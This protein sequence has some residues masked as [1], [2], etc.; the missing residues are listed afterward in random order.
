MSKDA[1][2][3]KYRPKKLSELVGQEHVIRILTNSIKRDKY[4]HAYIFAGKFGCGKTSTARIFAAAVNN[5][6]GP[7]PD[8][9]LSNDLIR[10]IFEGKHPDVKEI[11]AAASGSIDGIRELKDQIKYSPMECRYRFVIIDEA[12]RLSGAAAEAALKMIEEPPP[13][14]I[15]ILATTDPQKLKDTIHSRCLPLRFNK[16]SWNQAFHH[17]KYVADAEGLDYEDA[18]LKIAARKSRGSARNALQNLEMLIS[19]AGDGEKISVDIARQSLAAIDEN[20]F[21]DLVDAIVRPDAGEAMRIIDELLSDGRDVGEVLDG[22]VGHLR[23]LLIITTCPST[24]GLLY[25]ADDEKKRYLHQKDNL[26]KGRA[27]QFLVESLELLQD[28]YRGIHLNLNPQVM[29]EQFAVRAA[30]MAANLRTKDTARSS[31]NNASTKESKNE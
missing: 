28:C 11:D 12:H 16:L 14:V 10:R 18:A 5:P 4:H 24:K 9:D 21:F 22:L 1:L 26:P 7:T 23:N 15:F 17:L 8:P 31:P 27:A 29:I 19:F 13:R 30:I 25:L 3:L 2:A 20:K 6:D